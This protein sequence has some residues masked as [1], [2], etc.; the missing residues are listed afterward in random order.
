MWILI[1]KG[2]I[3]HF[4][5]IDL[6]WNFCL[7]PG[8]IILRGVSFLYSKIRITGRKRYQ[9]R[10]YF[11][12]LVS[13]PGW[14]ELWKRESKISLWEQTDLLVITTTVGNQ[15]EVFANAADSDMLEADD[16]WPL[17]H[18]RLW[19]SGQLDSL[20]FHTRALA[21]FLAFQNLWLATRSLELKYRGAAFRKCSL[22]YSS[23]TVGEGFIQKRR[24]RSPLLL[25][26][27]NWFN[28][29]PRQLFCTRAI[30]RTQTGV[31]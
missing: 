14:F 8:S 26:R 22:L 10:N 3:C 17:W 24:Q 21:A 27:Q 28:S 7:T 4:Y 20:I 1:L 18:P 2:Y 23:F 6:G 12:T 9:N 5:P 16:W 25:G 19:S 30:W 11:N 13:G 29:L 15:G 31:S